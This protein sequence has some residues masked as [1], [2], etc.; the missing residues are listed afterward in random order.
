M[1][2]PATDALQAACF[3]AWKDPADEAIAALLRH[4]PDAALHS[5]AARRRGAQTIHRSG[6]SL[7]SKHNPEVNNCRCAACYRR[8]ARKVSAP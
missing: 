8:R 4:V 6:G 3:A 5:E 7:W 2:S 1:T